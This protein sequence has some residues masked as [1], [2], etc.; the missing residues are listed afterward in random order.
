VQPAALL[1]QSSIQPLVAIVQTIHI[2][3]VVVKGANAT[4][5]GTFLFFVEW[6]VL[7][8][9]TFL[10]ARFD[11]ASRFWVRFFAAASE[12]FLARA[13]RSSGVMVSRLRLP[14]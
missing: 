13:E 7:S 10:G 12:A 5:A 4:F 8:Q 1:V 11:A 2:F 6:V 9:P 14:P 3:R